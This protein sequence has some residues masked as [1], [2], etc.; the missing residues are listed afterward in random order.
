MDPD[1]SIITIISVKFGFIIVLLWKYLL[2]ID[3]LYPKLIGIY[4]VPVVK[5]FSCMPIEARGFYIVKW[6]VISLLC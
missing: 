6:I 4:A 5:R 1:L 2:P 3:I